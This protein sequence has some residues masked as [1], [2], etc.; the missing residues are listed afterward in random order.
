MQANKA[1]PAKSKLEVLPCNY[2]PA[3]TSIISIRY[4]YSRL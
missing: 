1:Y 3:I 2:F 4:I